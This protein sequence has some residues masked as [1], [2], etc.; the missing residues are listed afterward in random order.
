MAASNTLATVDDIDAKLTALVEILAEKLPNAFNFNLGLPPKQ[1]CDSVDESLRAELPEPL[2]ELPRFAIF[3]IEGFMSIMDTESHSSPPTLTYPWPKQTDFDEFISKIF[4]T[5]HEFSRSNIEIFGLVFLVF[6]EILAINPVEDLWEAFCA[7]KPSPSENSVAFYRI[8]LMKFL[9]S[10][11]ELRLRSEA[12]DNE[13]EDMRMDPDS[14]P[15]AQNLLKLIF[16]PHYFL[17]EALPVFLNQLEELLKDL[18]C[19]ELAEALHTRISGGS[20]ADIFKSVI[21]EYMKNM[22]SEPG[23]SEDARSFESA[24]PDPLRFTFIRHFLPD[25]I[26]EYAF[27][28]KEISAIKVAFNTPQYGSLIENYSLSTDLFFECVEICLKSLPNDA[29]AYKALMNGLSSFPST[30][31]KYHHSSEAYAEVLNAV[32]E[33]TLDILNFRTKILESSLDKKDSNAATYLE[34]THF[35]CDDEAVVKHP[36]TDRILH[37]TFVDLKQA[38]ALESF[39]KVITVQRSILHQ[40]IKA[41]DK[42]TRLEITQCFTLLPQNLKAVSEIQ[43]FLSSLIKIKIHKNWAKQAEE[44]RW[45]PSSID[46]MTPYDRNQILIYSLQRDPQYWSASF[47]QCFTHVLNWIEKNPEVSHYSPLIVDSLLKASQEYYFRHLDKVA[48]SHPFYI[49][50]VLNTLISALPKPMRRIVECIFHRQVCDSPAEDLSSYIVNGETLAFAINFLSA[51]HKKAELKSILQNQEIA[52]RVD[53]HEL[54]AVVLALKKTR[55]LTFI[56]PWLQQTSILAKIQHPLQLVHASIQLA[57]SPF[58]ELST[59]FLKQAGIRA[60]Y[61]NWD[62]NQISMILRRLQRENFPELNVIIFDHPEM[63]G[64]IKNANHLASLILYLKGASSCQ[65]FVIALIQHPEI[66]SRIETLAQLGSVMDALLHVNLAQLIPL[67]LQD[68]EI[69]ARISHEFAHLENMT[70]LNLAIGTW[71]EEAQAVIRKRFTSL[72]SPSTPFWG[73]RKNEDPDDEGE[74]S[75]R[76]EALG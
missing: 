42:A 64:H 15:L 54:A 52:E 41:S 19:Q 30:T 2:S 48:A 4:E 8:F 18:D 39:K 50:E 72:R 1:K 3:G 13:E 65:S 76:H 28:E 21:Q 6:S 67:L 69:L 16:N 47:H 26:G 12:E 31:G 71:P 51:A 37:S 33:Q 23:T 66:R 7:Q 40:K 36:I 55:W 10:Q 29:F 57:V 5:H 24:Y 68:R 49:Q 53:Y 58:P 32:A 43:R 60:K 22:P 46:T 35:L 17:Q 61:Q 59:D 62:W 38:L 45:K 70:Q 34:M 25:Y 9:Q 75:K 74:S 20:K 63:L 56:T 44:L 73:K 11:L 14:I 27:S